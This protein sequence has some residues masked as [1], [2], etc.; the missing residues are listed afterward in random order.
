MN[1]GVFAGILLVLGFL[2]RFSVF[3]MRTSPVAATLPIEAVDFV[4]ALLW[5]GG[6]F[7]LAAHWRLNLTWGF[8]G[9][10]FI[11]GLLLMLWA[12][13]KTSRRRNSHRYPYDYP[14]ERDEATESPRKRR[15]SKPRTYDY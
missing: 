14:E 15:D 11:F 12:S 2:V 8:A 9:L 10:L 1:K 4:S 5:L 7:L 6:S 3:V 13:S